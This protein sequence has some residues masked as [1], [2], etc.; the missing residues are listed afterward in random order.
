VPFDDCKGEGADTSWTKELL[1]I[2]FEL[3]GPAG[4]KRWIEIDNVSFSR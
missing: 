2:A 3:S 4:A 1:T